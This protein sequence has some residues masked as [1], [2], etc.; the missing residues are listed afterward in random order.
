M[1]GVASD[2]AASVHSRA[3]GK[4][5]PV[6]EPQDTSRHDSFGSLVD[7]IRPRSI[8]NN[9]PSQDTAAAA[10]RIVPPQDEVSAY[11]RDRPASRRATANDDTD[12]SARHRERRD[13]RS[14]QA[15]QGQVRSLR[16]EN[17][18]RNRRTPGRQR[19]RRH[20]CLPPPMPPCA[21][22]RRRSPPIRTPHRWPRPRRGRSR[23]QPRPAGDAAA[24][25]R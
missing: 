9:A 5:Q 3:R 1:V 13:G 20:R 25:S 21:P 12:T 2:V 23:T 4:S 22:T 15:D 24:F 10:D 19:T 8:S 16:R 7:S 18:R 6:A 17:R 11:R 14:G